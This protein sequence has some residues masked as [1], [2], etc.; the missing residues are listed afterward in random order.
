MKAKELMK[1][2]TILVEKYGEDT[3]VAIN[4]DPDR[5]LYP[6]DECYYDTFNR[7]IVIAD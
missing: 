1:Y 5:E 6:V 3:T 7:I 2:L 4:S